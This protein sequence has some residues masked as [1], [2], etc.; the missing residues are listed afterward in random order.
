MKY[1]TQYQSPVGQLTLQASDHLLMILLV[2]WLKG[3]GRGVWPGTLQ[4]AE[5]AT[6]SGASRRERSER[7]LA[8]AS[9]RVPEATDETD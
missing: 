6:A 4:R 2:L 3:G 5:R 1:F 9:G 7:K 8:D